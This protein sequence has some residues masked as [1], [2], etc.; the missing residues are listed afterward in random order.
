MREYDA[1]SVD[2]WL[3]WFSLL[4]NSDDDTDDYDHNHTKNYTDDDDD[5]VTSPE[6]S[7]YIDSVCGWEVE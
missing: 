6:S 7:S 4:A 2:I 1:V 5:D 3:I